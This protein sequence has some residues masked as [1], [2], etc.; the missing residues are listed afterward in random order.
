MSQK[1]RTLIVDDVKETRKNI[2][3]LLEFESRIEVIGEAGNGEEALEATAKLKPDVILMDINMPI[4]DGLKASE[5][6]NEEFP[7]IIVIIMSVQGEREYLKKAMYCGAKEYLVKPFSLDTLID[8]VIRTYD[9]EQNRKKYITSTDNENNN[10][11]KSKVVTVFSTKGGVGKTTVAINTALSIAKRTNEKVAVID[12]DLQ[13]GDVAVMLNITPSKTI[14]NL[15]DEIGHLNSEVLKEYMIEYMKGVDVLAAPIKP[16]HAEYISSSHI[17]KI[18]E[19]LKEDYGYIIFDSVSNFSD[20]TLT[21]LDN[22]DQVYFIATMNLATI[23]NVKL[24]LEIMNSLHYHDEKVKIVLNKISK[25]F[26]IKISDVEEV[27]GRPVSICIPEDNKTVIP[28]VNKGYPFMRAR[29]DTKISKSIKRLT[30]LIITG[31]EKRAT[32]GLSRGLFNRKK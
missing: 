22:S 6:I 12:L 3:T 15:I 21:A 26:G 7:E 9:K 30:E 25:H 24:G 18:I 32:K 5:K 19:V 10:R 4:M 8:T 13:F 1:I 11:M 20:I 28:S 16:E 31:K 17:E 27:L 2:M 14:I 23:K 29:S